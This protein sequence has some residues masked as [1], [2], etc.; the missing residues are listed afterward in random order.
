MASGADGKQAYLG[1]LVKST[2]C[3]G[4]SKESTKGIYAVEASDFRE[5]PPKPFLPFL[6]SLTPKL[7]PGP[8]LTTSTS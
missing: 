6:T 1:I 7:Y 3:K 2:A 8:V 4:G 5:L